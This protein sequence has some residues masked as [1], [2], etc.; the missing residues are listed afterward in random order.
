MLYFALMAK[1]KSF[2]PRQ[3]KFIACFVECLNGA[4]AARRAGYGVAGARQRAEELRSDP[5]IAAEIDRLLD[6]QLRMGEGEILA[7]LERQATSDISIFFDAEGGLRWDEVLKNGDLIQRI[8][9][10]AEGWRLVLHDPQKALELLGKS[11]AMFVERTL[12]EKLEGLEVVDTGN[13]KAPRRSPA[14][15]ARAAAGN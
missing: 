14:R 4:E 10:T 6:K 11:K 8:W 1:A 3:R 2:P 15:A 7:R 9:K 12:V 5:R 13:G